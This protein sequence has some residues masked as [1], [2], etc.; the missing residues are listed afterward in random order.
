MTKQNSFQIKKFPM[1]GRWH[2]VFFLGICLMPWLVLAG[3]AGVPAKSALDAGGITEPETVDSGRADLYYHV[4]H[5][6]KL[7]YEG[8]IPEAVEILKAAVANNPESPDVLNHLVYFL[9]DIAFS[10]PGDSD[11]HNYLLQA[12]TYCEEGIKQF[13]DD[14]TLYK[15]LSDLYINSQRYH[16]T[17]RLYNV[18]YQKMPADAEIGITLARLYIQTNQF[19]DA[20]ATLLSIEQPDEHPEVWKVF[21]LLSGE[22]AKFSESITYYL[23]FLDRFSD[24]YEARYNLAICYLNLEDYTSALTELEKLLSQYPRFAEI[25]LKLAEVYEKLNRFKDAINILE[26]VLPNPTVAL[27]ARINIGRLLLLNGEPDQ[28]EIILEAVLKDKP[29]QQLAAFYFALSLFDQKNFEEAYKYLNKRF[30]GQK[31]SLPAVDLMVQ[32]LIELDN[33]VDALRLLERAIREDDEEPQYY[34]LLAELYK[35]DD[36]RED[37]IRAYQ[38]GLGKL[39]RHRQLNLALAFYFDQIGEWRKGVSLIEELMTHYPGDAE[40]MNYIGY[41][42]ADNND[43]LDHAEKLI[44]AALEKAPDTPAYLDSLGWVYYRLNRLPEALKYLQSA[45]DLLTRYDPII[46][47]HLVEVNIAS[48]NMEEAESLL[49]TGLEMYPDNSY[50]KDLQ[51]QIEEAGSR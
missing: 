49:K 33:I 30:S 19:E 7:R 38:R 42:L 18:L 11:E 25:N 15:V 41:T 23:Q 29:G 39:P 48:E 3:C 2:L 22:Q 8:R 6:H 13:P 44:K 26:R 17:I 20:E 12:E 43:R 9:L 46:I 31:L 37:A 50:L 4:L 5:A 28:A 10:T 35:I 47:A 40:L 51:N 21:G 36:H 16:A 1:N 34:L 14:T 45:F 27:T 32:T 24:D